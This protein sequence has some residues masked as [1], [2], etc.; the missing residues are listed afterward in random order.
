MAVVW[1]DTLLTTSV[2]VT[3]NGAF[4]S[5]TDKPTLHAVGN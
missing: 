5:A 3:D 1:N 4:D 2:T